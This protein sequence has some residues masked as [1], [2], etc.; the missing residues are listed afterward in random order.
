[1]NDRLLNQACLKE[2]NLTGGERILDVGSGLG[3]FTCLMAKA[4]GSQGSVLGIE[5]DPV[6]LSGA[7][8]L[9]A[10]SPVDGHLAFRSGDALQLPLEGEE[11]GSFD[12]AH[13]RFVL[14][15]VPEPGKV[16]AQM[17]KAVRPGGRV[18]LADD[19]HAQFTPYPAP[20]G[21]HTI[22][23][24][25]CRSYDRIGC[26]AFVGRRLTTF[27]VEAGLK[28][29]RNTLVF[30]G[31]C[32]GDEVFEIAALNIIKILEGARELMLEH[33]LISIENYEAG[34][35]GLRRWM[36]LSDAALWYGMNWVEG[37]KEG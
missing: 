31:G 24:A 16:V 33:C 34:I 14:E 35:A 22:W 3:Q 29:R 19:D 32:A 23:D 4:A 9:I 25:Y 26:D 12:L 17:A 20:P 6:Q 28:P 1:M 27:L 21:F 10:R 5:R 37:V 36:T 30:F 7:Q 18:V 8:D 11:W 2:L 15:H 13:T